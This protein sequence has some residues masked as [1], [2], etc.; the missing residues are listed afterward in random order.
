MMFARAID[1]E[2]GMAFH[3]RADMHTV[4]RFVGV[5][6][7]TSRF[8]GKR[9]VRVLVTGGR[10]FVADRDALFPLVDWRL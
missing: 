6:H 1:M 3:C 4:L 8:P 9:R 10:P 7:I 2:P 5:E